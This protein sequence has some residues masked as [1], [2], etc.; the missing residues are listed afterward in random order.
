MNAKSKNFRRVASADAALRAYDRSQSNQRSNRPRS[1]RASS[2]PH[3]Y[4]RP[5]RSQNDSA[6]TYIQSCYADVLV[7]SFGLPSP[8]YSGPVAAQTLKG[9]FRL[10]QGTVNSLGYI[11]TVLNPTLLPFTTLQ[12][13][14]LAGGTMANCAVPT[15]YTN[16]T[17]MD[18]TGLPYQDNSTANQTQLFLA[19]Q[20]SSSGATQYTGKTR[21]LGI[22]FRLTYLGTVLDRGGEVVIFDNP[23]NIALACQCDDSATGGGFRFRT[24]F[25]SS[26]EID[27]AYNMVTRIPLDHVVEWVWRPTDLDFKDVSTLVADLASNVAGSTTGSVAAVPYLPSAETPNATTSM[28]WVA[29]FQVRPAKALT[30]TVS[31]YRLDIE[32]YHESL[33]CVLDQS[34]SS[35][36]A[37]SVITPPTHSVSKDSIRSDKISNALAHVHAS[38]RGTNFTGKNLKIPYKGMLGGIVKEGASALMNAAAERAVAAF[39]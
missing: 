33:F 8:N 4:S 29:G 20:Q 25:N 13:E 12:Y 5:K 39:A 32:S 2:R 10:S 28:G 21:C 19:G 9:S 15:M 26:A 27:A 1:H 18:Y 37:A 34:I 36:T 16:S 7:P 23:Q 38:R 30:S 11:S 17:N 31:N 24:A 3:P 6:T 22:K 14:K 35:V